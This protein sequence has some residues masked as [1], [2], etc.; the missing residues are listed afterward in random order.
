MK[1]FYKCK[2]FVRVKVLHLNIGIQRIKFAG[3]RKFD[4]RTANSPATVDDFRRRE[5]F[6]R[7]DFAGVHKAVESR[8]S[9]GQKGNK[10]MSNKPI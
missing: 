4:W 6:T 10:P 3:A 8:E 2:G 7:S 1:Y 5:K 9:R